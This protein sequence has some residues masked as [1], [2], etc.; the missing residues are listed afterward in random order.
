M[1]E[2]RSWRDQGDFE[3]V[4]VDLSARF[5]NFSSDEIED[6]ITA[7]LGTIGK[8]FGADRA[9]IGRFTEGHRRFTMTHEWNRPEVGPAA[10]TWIAVPSSMFAG[11]LRAFLRNETVFSP[12]VADLPN[13]E[14]RER[15]LASGTR[16]LMLTP[17]VY[18]GALWGFVGLSST[19][20]E[21]NWPQHAPRL[22]GV[23]GQMCVTALER[24]RSEAALRMTRYSVEHSADAAF[25]LTSDA[26]FI[27]VNDAACD[28]LGYSREELLRMS[29]QDIDPEFPREV[30][31]EHWAHIKEVGKVTIESVHRRKD[32]TEFPVEIRVNFQRF[33]GREYNFSFAR[34]ITERKQAE[35]ER[36]RLASATRQTAESVLLTDE[37]GRIQYVNPA[38]ERTTGR[39]LSDVV[40]KTLRDLY[41]NVEEGALF[42]NLWARLNEGRQWS[43]RISSKREDG[44]ALEEDVSITAITDSAGGALGFVSVARDVTEQIRMETLLRQSQKMEA[45]GQLAGGV[46]HD[47]NNILQAIKG[48]TA[49]T[50]SVLDRDDRAQ[51]YL[52][53]VEKA[54]DR[55]GDL[56]RQL[57]TFSRHE[58]LRHEYL[59]LADVVAGVMKML[60]R[61]IGENLEFEVHTA[62]D[63]EFVY[64]DR[65]QIEQVLMNLCVNARDAMPDGGRITIQ[66][67][68]TEFDRDGAGENRWARPGRFAWFSVRDTGCGISDEVAERIFEPFFTTKGIGEG[69]GLGL[70]T[71]YAIVERHEGL[72]HLDSK[73]HGGC[74]FEVYL[75]VKEPTR[76][77]DDK[78]EFTEAASGGTETVLIAEDDRQ[79]RKLAVEVLSR[80]GYRVI[81]AA[82]GDEAVRKFRR[83]ENTIDLAVLDVVMPGRSGRDVHDLIRERRPQTT[84]LFSS[85]YGFNAL[86]SEDLPEGGFDVIAKP[87]KPAYL[88]RRVREVLESEERLIG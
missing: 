22:L 80:A 87:Y 28:S 30:W 1:T 51:T 24:K 78:E 65:G 48:Y 15:I 60:R 27:Y 76:D 58:S 71:V 3:R 68:V 25:W 23:F 20:E 69:T 56:V 43:G 2:A 55:A 73:P 52:V 46:A 62:S 49:L 35:D 36:L 72:L 57:L 45:I 12:R 85:G 39:R 41:G 64:A 8:F 61:L 13:R 79:V 4:A 31:E 50:Q 18:E 6:G 81:Q 29:A 75:P 10:P 44:S 17:L 88:L 16:S 7:A 32:G 59:N 21:Q 14:A 9:Y 63:G 67:G 34:D 66:T 70:A 47:F 54:S 38:F 74:T 82:D 83:Y 84:I 53:E 37:E 33:E 42:H 11:I 5:I 77:P 40:G 26:R 86:E 19:T